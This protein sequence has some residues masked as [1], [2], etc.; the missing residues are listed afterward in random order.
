MSYTIDLIFLTIASSDKKIPIDST[1][2]SFSVSHIP[3]CHFHLLDASKPLWLL[4]S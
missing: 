2:L 1:I 4:G 3:M